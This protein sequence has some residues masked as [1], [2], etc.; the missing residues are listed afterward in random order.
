MNKSFS[1]KAFLPTKGKRILKD[2]CRDFELF[3]FIKEYDSYIFT[4]A[5]KSL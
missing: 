3:F 4:S 1:Q 5:T 2:K